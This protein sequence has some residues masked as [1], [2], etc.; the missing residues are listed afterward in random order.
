MSKP[1]CGPLYRPEVPNP[2]PPKGYEVI[3]DDPPIRYIYKW[4]KYPLEWGW[5]MRMERLP[6]TDFEK[7][8]KEMSA[9]AGRNTH[10]R[11]LTG[12]DELGF[13]RDRQLNPDAGDVEGVKDRLFGARTGAS[14]MFWYHR[15]Q[16]LIVSKAGKDTTHRRVA[17]NPSKWLTDPNEQKAVTDQQNILAFGRIEHRGGAGWIHVM[18]ILGS[19]SSNVPK[20]ALRTLRRRYPKHKITD[21]HGR[22]I[23]ESR[24]IASFR[25][26]VAIN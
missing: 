2:M 26:W 21:G 20:E 22:E 24:G 13:L 4:V 6:V 3:C 7:K 25:E 19:Y 23:T 15:T 18:D 14:E 5:E 12:H 11:H 16:G 17:E 8:W 9:V 10:N 1:K